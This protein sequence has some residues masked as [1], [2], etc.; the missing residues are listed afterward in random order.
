MIRQIILSVV[1]L[2]LVICCAPIFAEN[3]SGIGYETVTFEKKGNSYGVDVKY[4]KVTDERFSPN[5]R[6]KVN[7][8]IEKFAHEMFDSDFKAFIES[9]SKWTKKE[10]EDIAG[11]DSVDIS[12]DIIQ[13]DEHFVSIRFEKYFYGIGAA[14]GLTH[15]SG[16]NYDVKQLSIV[17][18]TNLFELGIDYLKRLSDYCVSDLS[19]QLNRSGDNWIKEGAAPNEEN[20]KEFAVGKDSLIIYFSD[21]QVADYASGTQKV[22]IPFNKLLGIKQL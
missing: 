3:A 2:F 11:R 15:I 16:F 9:E 5:V 10:L 18:L 4:P 8:E 19:K 7:D 13:I 17:K 1:I 14:H 6:Q 12:F 21:Y 20:F 22:T